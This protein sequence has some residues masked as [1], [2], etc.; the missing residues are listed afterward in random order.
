MIGCLLHAFNGGTWPATEAFALT[1]NRTGDHL[2]CR[3][4]LNPLSH[5]IRAN[6]LINCG[7]LPKGAALKIPTDCR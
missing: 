1:G 6:F 7:T 3:P 5:S 4:V 2:V